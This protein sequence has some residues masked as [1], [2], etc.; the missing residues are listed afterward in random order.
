MLRAATD[1]DP[2]RHKSE[3]GRNWRLYSRFQNDHVGSSGDT[4]YCFCGILPFV[5]LGDANPSA[6]SWWDYDGHRRTV[7]QAEGGD[8]GGPLMP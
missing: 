5:H 3:R 6:Y 2:K 1:I 4:A 7:T 8:Q